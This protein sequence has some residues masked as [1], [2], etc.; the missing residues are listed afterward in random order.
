MKVVLS[1]EKTQ[2]KIILEMY[3]AIGH[4]R[5]IKRLGSN[6]QGIHY[7]ALYAH[8]YDVQNDQTK[9]KIRE[10]LYQ[11]LPIVSTIQKCILIYVH[12]G[13]RTTRNGLL[14]VLGRAYRKMFT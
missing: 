10:Y 7:Y 2:E 4:F 14:Y 13:A 1:R 8:Q 11:S 5:I 12:T 6:A 9:E 3:K